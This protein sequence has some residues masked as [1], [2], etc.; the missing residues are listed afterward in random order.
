M[1]SHQSRPAR[2]R[3]VALIL[4]VTVLV[5]GSSYLLVE[6]LNRLLNATSSPDRDV[7]VLQKAKEGLL[8]YASEQ[9]VSQNTPGSLPCPDINNDG[10]ADSPC[11]GANLLGRLPWKTLNLP[12]LRD[13]SGERLWY[14]LSTEFRNQSSSVVN[15]DTLGSLTVINGENGAIK[16]ANVIAIVFASGP[17]IAGQN[18]AA[19]PNLPANYIEGANSTV[20][21]STSAASSLFAGNQCFNGGSAVACNDELLTL[22][23]AELFGVIT[24]LIARRL[25]SGVLP[26]LLTQYFSA[27]VSYPFPAP[28]GID[29]QGAQDN[30]LGV[31]GTKAGWLPMTNS[32]SNLSWGRSANGYPVTLFGA[33]A[34]DCST[35]TSTQ[36]ICDVTQTCDGK[37]TPVVLEATL[38]N[39]GNSFFIYT[40]TTNGTVSYQ[41]FT[42]AILKDLGNAYLLQLAS[43]PLDIS[44]QLIKHNLQSSGHDLMSYSFNLPAVASGSTG[45]KNNKKTS[46]VTLLAPSK[47]PS[48]STPWLT[49]LNSPASG[50]DLYWFY[51]NK[52]YQQLLYAV[53][54]GYAPGGGVSCGAGNNNCIS[55][56]LPD[57]TVVSNKQVI[58]IFAGRA[59]A[60]Q[61]RSTVSSRT[62]PANYFESDN[63]TISDQSFILQRYSR[64][65]NDS[66]V[67]AAPRTP[68][69]P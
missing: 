18:R 60:T 5:L 20:S 62:K 63:S 34:S 29:P 32:L 17:A 37:L 65:F 59:L 52:W 14:A 4:F 49:E 26:N 3:G 9:A 41:N 44:G 48:Y 7:A 55:V 23:H 27:W 67:F 1:I 30:L 33:P 43:S 13:S 66:F 53:A 46:T 16:E 47:W 40:T 36:L 54:P 56:T 25:Q 6:Q 24:P 69:P 19:K 45:C 28:F 31:R 10:N 15:S 50:T 57:G 38:L 64:I 61:D 35:S 68:T 58:L 42:P 11:S 22:G 12:D 21:F 2:Q 51:K 39:A 8:G